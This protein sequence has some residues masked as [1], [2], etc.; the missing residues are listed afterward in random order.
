MKAFLI[1]LSLLS[2][3]A[4]AKSLKVMQ[5]NAENLFDTTFD[6]GR[7]DFTYLPLSLKRSMP[8]HTAYCESMGG[9]F[10]K[11]ECLN[12]DWTPAKLDKKLNNLG[13][14]IKSFDQ[15]GKGPD[16]II[17]QEVENLNVLRL[18]ASRGL[19][20]MGYEH[21]VLIEGD[22]SRG[23]DVGILSKY[24]VVSGKRYSIFV[25]GQKL[26]TRGITEATFNINGKSVVVFGN[27]W[28]SQSNPVEE[29][30]ESAKVLAKAADSKSAD[31][32]IAVGDFN[33]LPKDIPSPFAQLTS[34]ID[35]EVQAR[36]INSNLNPGTHYYKG[37]WSSLDKIFIHK[38]SRMVADFSTYEIIKRD[39][40]LMKDPKT[41]A[42]VPMRSNAST[43]QGYSD[44]LPVGLIFNY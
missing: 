8:E 18:L 5:F 15:S 6:N 25:N 10:Y 32:I 22:D 36:K 26:D 4:S 23:I 16:I 1:A 33:T 9:G 3:V 38:K 2:T 27:H 11:D 31:L 7:N 37:E 40:M 39:F 20:G 41:G 29:R 44:H 14:V 42:M 21:G 30:I 34:F 24:P 19:A 12:L 13:R 17:L 28:P 43:G 35:S